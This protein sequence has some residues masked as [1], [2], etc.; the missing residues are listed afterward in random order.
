MSTSNDPMTVTTTAT[1]VIIKAPTVCVSSASG[2]FGEQSHARRELTFK[3]RTR[4]KHI[5]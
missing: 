3:A 5:V 2:L 4:G 1:N